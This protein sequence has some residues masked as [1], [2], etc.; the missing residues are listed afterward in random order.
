[1]R[2]EDLEAFRLPKKDLEGS[3]LCLESFGDGGY[4][5]IA[6]SV[7]VTGVSEPSVVVERFGELGGKIVFS[8][9]SALSVT[10]RIVEPLAKGEL[11]VDFDELGVRGLSVSEL[12]GEAFLFVSLKFEELSSR[13]GTFVGCFGIVPKIFGLEL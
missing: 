2:W 10:E 1:M 3:R 8:V 12:K 7:G 13:E 4:G 9:T 5:G 6:V 11:G